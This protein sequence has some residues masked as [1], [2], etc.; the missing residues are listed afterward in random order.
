MAAD[1][2]WHRYFWR[3][4]E[5]ADW[6][7]IG[8]AVKKS[9]ALDSIEIFG[10]SAEK[11]ESDAAI[12]LDSVTHILPAG[13]EAPIAAGKPSQF[14]EAAMPPEIL[15]SLPGV[16]YFVPTGWCNQ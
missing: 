15:V 4:D 5:P 10:P 1:G 16:S 12:D 6:T 2:E 7:L 13:I 11:S 3:I 8:A 9:F 14:R